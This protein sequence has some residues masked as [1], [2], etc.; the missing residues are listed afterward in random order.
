MLVA[1]AIPLEGKSGVVDAALGIY[2]TLDIRAL[3]F[4]PEKMLGLESA[5]YDEFVDAKGQAYPEAV[6]EL[7]RGCDYYIHVSDAFRGVVAHCVG[8]GEW[9]HTRCRGA[10]CANWQCRSKAK[11]VARLQAKSRDRMAK[12]RALAAVRRQ[13]SDY[14]PARSSFASRRAGK[15]PYP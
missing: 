14:F 5:W 4:C 15:R 12:R 11:G 10:A 8:C 6:G 13:N 3:A 7:C 1:D 2:A 9:Q